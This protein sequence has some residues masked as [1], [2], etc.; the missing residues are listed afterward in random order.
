MVEVFASIGSIES[1]PLISVPRPPKVK[2]L[3]ASE[4]FEPYEATPEDEKILG[5]D[6]S[7]D[8]FFDN[9][10]WEGYYK[11]AI[12]RWEYCCLLHKVLTRRQKMKIYRDLGLPSIW[13]VIQ[14]LYQL[15]A[16]EPPKWSTSRDVLGWSLRELSEWCGIKDE[17]I[18]CQQVMHKLC[19]DKGAVHSM[20]AVL[21]N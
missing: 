10:V 3:E 9:D 5:Y 18:S 20:R 4:C 1:F 17:A 14:D 13:Q 2:E 7:K 12:K 21:E 19:R 15:T 8:S 16:K 6:I 11:A